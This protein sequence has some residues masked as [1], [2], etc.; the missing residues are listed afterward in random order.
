MYCA[1]LILNIIFKIINF[2]FILNATEIQIGML[3][4]SAIILFIDSFILWYVFS[5]YKLVTQLLDSEV[6][7]LRTNFEVQKKFIC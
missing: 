4:F 6:Y 7:Y 5:F 1:Y 3:I 2:G